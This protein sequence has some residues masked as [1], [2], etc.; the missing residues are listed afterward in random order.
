M[1]KAILL[2]VFLLTACSSATKF[3]G[4][5]IDGSITGPELDHNGEVW[6]NAP[7][8]VENIAK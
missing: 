8:V 7:S 2:A 6:R 5:K 1:K 4:G 3:Q